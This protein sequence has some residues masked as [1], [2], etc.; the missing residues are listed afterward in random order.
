[1]IV[2]G[3][4]IALESM[5]FA[6]AVIRAVEAWG[7]PAGPRMSQ[8]AIE[9]REKCRNSYHMLSIGVCERVERFALRGAGELQVHE[10]EMRRLM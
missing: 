5:P 10:Y 3:R 2:V 7:P 8:L 1:M 4:P 9:A 6:L